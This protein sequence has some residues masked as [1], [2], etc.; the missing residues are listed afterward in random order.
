MRL[1]VQKNIRLFE[2]GFLRSGPWNLEYRAD[3]FNI[4]NNPYLSVT[5]NDYRNLSSPNFGAYN[6]AAASR[7]IQMALK[8]TW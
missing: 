3:S 4:F 8:V 7:R 2:H 6:T 5:G 1:D